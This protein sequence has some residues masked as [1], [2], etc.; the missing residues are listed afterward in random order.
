MR[1]D[2]KLIGNYSIT[3]IEVVCIG[4]ISKLHGQQWLLLINEYLKLVSA[5]KLNFHISE[6]HPRQVVAKSFFLL[7]AFLVTCAFKGEACL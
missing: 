7:S 1:D 5:L 6:G 3:Y 2:K 4:L